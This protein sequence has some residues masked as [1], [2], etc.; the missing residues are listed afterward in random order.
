MLYL[1]NK[2]RH[3]FESV[4][5]LRYIAITRCEKSH[6]DQF[7]R[8]LL[9]LSWMS[10]IIDISVLGAIWTFAIEEIYRKPILK[11][12]LGKARFPI[13]YCSVVLCFRNFALITSVKRSCSERNSKKKKIY[14]DKAVVKS[15]VLVV[16]KAPINSKRTIVHLLVMA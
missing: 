3:Q 5:V 12:N 10:S 11:S 6:R 4:I 13:T 15:V 9:L 16:P 1:K 14:G 7:T 2:K 8:K